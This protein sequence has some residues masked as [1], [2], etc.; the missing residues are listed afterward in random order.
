MEHIIIVKIDSDRGAGEL[1]NEIQ[2][3]LDYEN[4]VAETF[5][6]SDAIQQLVSDEKGESRP[7]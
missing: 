1:V 4:I 2:A 7:R 6:A 3:N 5:V